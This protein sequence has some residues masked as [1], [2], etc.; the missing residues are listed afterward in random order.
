MSGLISLWDIFYEC[1]SF[2]I[3]NNY[4]SISIIFCS[5]NPEPIF[6]VY[7]NKSEGKYSIYNILLLLL[8]LIDFFLFY[9]IDFYYI[10]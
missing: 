10:N 9:L 2:N 8:F 4:L 5:N 3:I 6:K 7:V 1:N